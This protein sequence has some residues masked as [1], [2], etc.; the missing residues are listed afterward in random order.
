MNINVIFKFIKKTFTGN[1]WNNA[2]KYQVNSEKPPTEI[3]NWIIG[4]PN[5][6]LFERERTTKVK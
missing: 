1:L 2:I 4:E 5:A 6:I 3:A